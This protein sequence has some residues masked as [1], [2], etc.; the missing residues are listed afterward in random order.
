MMKN[1]ESILVVDDDEDIRGVVKNILEEEGYTVVTAENGSIALK[2]LANHEYDLIISDVIMPDMD[3]ME[4]LR[5]LRKRNQEIPSI[6]MSGDP[7]GQKFLQGAR[8]LG[9]R[10]SLSKPFT[11]GELLSTVRSVLE[12]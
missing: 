1:T 9:A 12:S 6:I 11:K 8:L 10:S 5:N 4:F 3:G 7:M 2:E